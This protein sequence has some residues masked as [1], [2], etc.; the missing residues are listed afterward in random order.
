MLN[1]GGAHQIFWEKHHLFLWSFF[2]ICVFP[3]CW[4]SGRWSSVSQKKGNTPLS[5]SG[6]LS[7]KWHFTGNSLKARLFFHAFRVVDSFSKT[8]IPKAW[9]F[10]HVGKCLPLLF[11]GIP[12]PAGFLLAIQFAQSVGVEFQVENMNK[13]HTFLEHIPSKPCNPEASKS[14]SSKSDVKQSFFKQNLQ[15]FPAVFLD[16]ICI[17]FFPTKDEKIHITW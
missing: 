3:F 7:G 13:T 4:K 16:N 15:H 8:N 2:W 1:F 10:R 11:R 6:G 9:M 17:P 12:Q 14:K 5:T